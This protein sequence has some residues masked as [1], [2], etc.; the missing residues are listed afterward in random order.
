LEEAKVIS[1]GEGE[2]KQLKWDIDYPWLDGEVRGRVTGDEGPL[3]GIR[4]ELYPDT[5]YGGDCDGQGGPL[6]YVLT[7]ATGQYQIGGLSSGGYRLGFVDLDGV[8]RTTYHTDM[9]ML[10]KALRFEVADGGTPVE[11][12]AKLRKGGGILGKA[13]WPDGK[14][15]EGITVW[16]MLYDKQEEN[17]PVGFWRPL[18]RRGRGG[19]VDANGD[20]WLSGLWAGTYRV[21]FSESVQYVWMRWCYPASFVV[22]SAADV[23]VKAGETTVLEPVELGNGLPVYLP[24]VR[25]Q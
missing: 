11:I 3:A 23:I 15:A 6:V 16:A 24:Q 7:D 10:P 18:E 22:E 17:D 14:A 20:Y 19:Q 25:Q 5:C 12:N 8:Y 21:C 4:V 13:Y 2:A 1:L 9:Q